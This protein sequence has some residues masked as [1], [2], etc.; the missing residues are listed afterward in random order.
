MYF[1]WCLSVKKIRE[2][3]DKLTSTFNGLILSPGATLWLSLVRLI[4]NYIVAIIVT[5][6]SITSVLAKLHSSN[7]QIFAKLRTLSFEWAIQTIFMQST[8]VCNLKFEKHN[9]TIHFI[10]CEI[11]NN[12]QCSLL[13]ETNAWKCWFRFK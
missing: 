13:P 3:G 12:S 4:K 6:N 5:K 9:N 11:K 10:S 2:A 8:W 7:A 1:E